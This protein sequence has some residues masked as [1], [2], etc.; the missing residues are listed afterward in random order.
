MGRLTKALTG[1]FVGFRTPP[2][3]AAA[4]LKVYSEDLARYPLD[5]TEYICGKFR[6]GAVEGHNMNFAPTIAQMVREVERDGDYIRSQ[7]REA[8]PPPPPPVHDAAS[9]IRVQAMVDD[10]KA[11]IAA[12]GSDID[13]M[14][15]SRRKAHWQHVLAR[16]TKK[17]IE[18][19][20]AE[21]VDPYAGSSMPVS[22]GLRR[23]LA[24]D[25]GSGVRE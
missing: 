9:N 23:I 10:L 13:K 21:G 19:C 4:M 17:L 12:H 6:R 24:R 25:T 14:D 11:D 20:E 22:M 18:E 2:A 7:R 15:E 8:L 5:I 16:G 1:M 3:E